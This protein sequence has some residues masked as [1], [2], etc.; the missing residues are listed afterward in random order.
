MPIADAL[1]RRILADNQEKNILAT[2][3]NL[4]A[5]HLGIRH[6]MQMISY[7][8]LSMQTHRATCVCPTEKTGTDN[9]MLCPL[10]NNQCRVRVPFPTWQR[11]GKPNRLRIVNP[12]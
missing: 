5:I 10:R 4:K 7:N 2:T 11:M 12:S 1:Y 9:N 3:T 6:G 8:S